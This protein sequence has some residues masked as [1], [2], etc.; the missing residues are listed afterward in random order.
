VSLDQQ[1]EAMGLACT[2]QTQLAQGRSVKS[3][4]G[5]RVEAYQLV[6]LQAVARTLRW[7]RDNE[8]A[9]KGCIGVKEPER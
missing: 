6:R 2:R 5:E 9:I 8:A 1:I 7:L 3:T 4:A